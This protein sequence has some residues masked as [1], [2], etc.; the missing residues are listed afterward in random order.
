MLLVVSTAYGV[1]G[2]IPAF[3]RLL[4][5]AARE[6]CQRLRQPLQVVALTDSPPPAERAAHS[7]QPSAQP[8]WPPPGLRYLACGGDRR[9]LVRA[10]LR[11]LGR[12]LPLVLG[13]VNLAPLG[14][15]WPAKVGVIVHGSEVYDPLPPL[16]RLALRRAGCVAAVSDHTLGCVVEQQ[17][18]AAGRCLRLVNALPSLPALPPPS[19]HRAPL[20]LLCISRLHPAEPKGVDSLLRALAWL[21]AEQARLTLIGEG[22]D[23]PRL[24]ALSQ[25]LGL[26]PDRVRFLGSVPD[27]VRDAELAGCDV[28]VLPSEGEGFGIVYLEAL[29]RGKPCIAARAGGAPEIVREGETGCLVPAPV[30]AHIPQLAATIASLSDPALRSRLGAAGRKRVEAQHT[31][32]AFQRRAAAL[33][34]ALAS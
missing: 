11:E 4:I 19:L 20:R 31:Y 10:C 17:G 1:Y 5:Q 18:V 3:N 6:H 16:R 27:S 8:G 33:F 28:F 9:A 22:E 26:L 34:S 25:T 12:P 24:Q 21:P 14:L 32:A 30:A 15:L 29:A 2:G 7:A 13:H 23:R